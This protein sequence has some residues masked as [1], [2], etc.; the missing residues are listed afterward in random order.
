MLNHFEFHH[1]ITNKYYLAV[2][3][4]TY[5]DVNIYIKILEK[6]VKC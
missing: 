4:K 6:S 5:C 3:F 2:N 1:E